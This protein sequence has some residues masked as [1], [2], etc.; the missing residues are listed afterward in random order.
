[1]LGIAGR[2]SHGRSQPQA[3]GFAP[4]LD[5]LMLCEEPKLAAITVVG[6]QRATALDVSRR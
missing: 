1:V 2:A 5:K 3:T 4:A 6:D